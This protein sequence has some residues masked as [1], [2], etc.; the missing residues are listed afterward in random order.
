MFL[1]FQKMDLNK[2]GVISVDEFMDTCRKV[3]ITFLL[4][5]SMS[6][7]HQL[8]RYLLLFNVAY[9]RKNFCKCQ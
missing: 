5:I 7:N 8:G 2:D 1:L 3:P 9:G 4:I 6:F